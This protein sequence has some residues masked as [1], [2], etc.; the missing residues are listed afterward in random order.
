MGRKRGAQIWGGSV[1][2]RGGG[3]I[4]APRRSLGNDT[5]GGGSNETGLRRN[6]RKGAEVFLKATAPLRIGLQKEGKAKEEEGKIRA[7]LHL[8]PCNSGQ[9]PGSH[10]LLY[11]PRPRCTQATPTRGRGHDAVWSPAPLGGSFPVICRDSLFLVSS[12]PLLSPH[13]PLHL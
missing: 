13:L 5:G 7:L 6:S 11:K 12:A 2:E 9:T 10:R 4:R 1:G 8:P 3:R